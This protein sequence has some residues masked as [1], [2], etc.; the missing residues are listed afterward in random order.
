MTTEKNE[1]VEIL[2][3][4]RDKQKIQIDLLGKIKNWLVF[5]GILTIIGL[6]F[7]ACSAIIP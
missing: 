2:Q 3:S 6:I 5:F 7:G 1:L 4:I